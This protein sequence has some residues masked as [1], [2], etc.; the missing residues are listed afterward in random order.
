MKP[1]SMWTVPLAAYMKPAP[2]SLLYHIFSIVVA[3]GI[4]TP[5]GLIAIMHMLVIPLYIVQIALL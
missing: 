5:A 2:S 3:A 1:F 4:E